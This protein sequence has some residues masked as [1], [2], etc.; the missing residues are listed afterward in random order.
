M[1]DRRSNSTRKTG[2]KAFLNTIDLLRGIQIDVD[3]LHDRDEIG[4]LG[5]SEIENN[6]IGEHE[7]TKFLI[8]RKLV[9]EEKSYMHWSKQ[10]R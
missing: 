9:H 2:E 4:D 5:C 1:K 7:E 10:K 3:L 8:A 6:E